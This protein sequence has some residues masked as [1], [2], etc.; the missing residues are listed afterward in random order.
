MLNEFL[1]QFIWWLIMTCRRERRTVFVV[2]F[3]KGEI[4]QIYYFTVREHIWIP[5]VS[6]IHWISCCDLFFI[7]CTTFRKKKRD[8]AIEFWKLQLTFLNYLFQIRLLLEHNRAVMYKGHCMPIFI[9]SPTK[10]RGDIG[11]PVS[12]HPKH[13]LWTHTSMDFYQTWYVVSTNKYLG[14]W[15]M[16]WVLRSKGQGHSGTCNF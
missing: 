9:P 6:I 4:I 12:V 13:F 1:W 11:T 14:P 8:F 3:C 2:R 15:Y 10:L 5:L 7:N 16:Y